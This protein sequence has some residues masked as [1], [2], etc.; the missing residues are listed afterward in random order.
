VIV[1]EEKNISELDFSRG[2]LYV[3][4]IRRKETSYA[5]LLSKEAY[6]SLFNQM[7]I[8]RKYSPKYFEIVYDD[9]PHMV[10]Y[11]LKTFKR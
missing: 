7:F 3:E 6:K 9:F 8:L 11:R 4:V 2:K 1:K 10:V 5:F